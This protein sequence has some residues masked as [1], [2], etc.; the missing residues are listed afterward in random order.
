MRPH[1]STREVALVL[2]VPPGT[3]KSRLYHAVRALRTALSIVETG[4]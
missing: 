3:V 4:R 1:K 2:G